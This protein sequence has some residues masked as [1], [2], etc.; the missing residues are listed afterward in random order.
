MFSNA[1]FEVRVSFP[2]RGN[3]NIVED[4]IKIY[5][6]PI[7]YNLSTGAEEFISFANSLVPSIKV[8]TEYSYETR[9]VYYLDMKVWID[10]K[11][12]IRTDLYRKENQ[13]LFTCF[14]LAATL[15]IYLTI[16]RTCLA[17]RLLRI[18]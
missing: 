15:S 14:R 12:F 17:Y 9:A 16:Y 5:I 7:P 13:K 3:Q 8:T 1:I 4:I 6:I 2:F 18:C 11:G 10:E